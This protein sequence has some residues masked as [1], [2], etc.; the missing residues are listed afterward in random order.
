MHENENEGHPTATLI[1]NWNQSWPT[2]EQK[3]K[4]DK[5]RLEEYRTVSSLLFYVF[6]LISIF[7]FQII[8]VF[9]CDLF[10]FHME[11]IL[12]CR[13]RGGGAGGTCRIK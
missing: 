3:K 13:Y 8:S 12:S 11:S 4:K 9:A 10:I 7:F 2:Y 1:P 5:V 6:A